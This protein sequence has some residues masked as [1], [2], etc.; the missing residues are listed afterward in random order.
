MSGT[1]SHTPQQEQWAFIT[2]WLKMLAIWTL[3][4][5]AVLGLVLVVGVVLV[6]RL[7][8]LFYSASPRFFPAGNAS[9]VI[10]QLAPRWGLVKTTPGAPTSLKN[11]LTEKELNRLLSAWAD[12]AMSGVLRVGVSPSPLWQHRPT[13]LPQKIGWLAPFDKR[14]TRTALLRAF[15]QAGLGEERPA[16]CQRLKQS[17]NLLSHTAQEDAAATY[18]W[19]WHNGA[20]KELAAVVLEE[21]NRLCRLLKKHMAAERLTL[22]ANHAAGQTCPA[23]IAGWPQDHPQEKDLLQDPFGGRFRCQGDHLLYGLGPNQKDNQAHPRKDQR[24][25]LP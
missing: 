15:Q 16:D 22:L 2:H 11:R 17:A 21:G 4:G 20:G 14:D 6:N 8:G 18:S 24:A 5:H 10:T 19:W 9:R 13:G 1:P 23:L 7:P 12:E 25:V 3:L